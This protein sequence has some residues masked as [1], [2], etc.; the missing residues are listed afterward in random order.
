MILTQDAKI[1][2]LRQGDLEEKLRRCLVAKGL[3]SPGIP[4]DIRLLKHKPGK[5]A[6]A[7][8]CFP[9]GG[10]D[11]QLILKLSRKG[12]GRSIYQKMRWLWEAGKCS[13]V[14]AEGGMP[15]PLCYLPE[16]DGILMTKV[17]GRA[18]D[19][20][21]PVR[22]QNQWVRAA[23][24]ALAW[25]HTLPLPEDGVFPRRSWPFWVE[26]F[27]L[28]AR[29]TLAD[30]LPAQAEATLVQVFAELDKAGLS[31]EGETRICHGDYSPT[32]L[33]FQDRRAVILDFDSAAITWPE[34]DLANFLLSLRTHLKDRFA[35]LATAFLEVYTSWHGFSDRLL[36]RFLAL[37]LVRRLVIEVKAAPVVE[38]RAEE[39]LALALDLLSNTKQW[40]CLLQ[41][42]PAIG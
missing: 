3:A 12:R 15:E 23:A 17:E 27:A 35:Q 18:F 19:A 8:V 10:G 24:Q 13:S 29:Q 16:L 33:L 4:I 31:V 34:L 5:Q 39:A 32:Q 30:R 2:A 7:W 42:L 38:G 14:K 1:P 11:R 25:L 40:Q 37:A 20:Q 41:P 6:V 26:K 28:K 22:I 21:V 9:A 36:N